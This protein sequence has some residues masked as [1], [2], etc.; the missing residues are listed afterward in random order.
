MAFFNNF[1]EKAKSAGKKVGDK[2]T[3]TVEVGKLKYKKG[4]LDNKIK[5]KYYEIGKSVFEK[6]KEGTVIDSDIAD[7]CGEIIKYE[8]E[9]ADLEKEI[10]KAKG[11]KTC[12]SCKKFVDA[13]F[14]FCPYC[15]TALED[16][17]ETATVDVD[18]TIDEA[19]S[20][21]SETSGSEGE[22]Q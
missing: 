5:A 19:P 14:A 2:T 22:A 16:E 20:T 7:A 1:V 10:N 6:Y 18:V 17:T 3:Q 13:Q 11:G 4:D 8:A 21:E 9:I 15:Q 12:P